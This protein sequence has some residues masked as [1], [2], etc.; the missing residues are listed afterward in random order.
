MKIQNQIICNQKFF[1][2][3][4]KAKC[5]ITHRRDEFI[6]N[7][8]G[9]VVRNEKGKLKALIYNRS[10]PVLSVF[11]NMQRKNDIFVRGGFYTHLHSEGEIRRITK[12]LNENREIGNM[13]VKALIGMGAFAFAFETE[14]GLVLKITEGKHFPYGRKPDDFDLPIIKSGKISPN[15]DLYYY[16]EEKARQDNMTD[17]EIRD[18]VG[19]IE[20]K[21]YFMR[22]YLRDFG[23]PNDPNSVIKYEQFGRA[24][25]GKIYLID[26]GCAY[27]YKNLIDDA[28]ETNFFSIILKKIKDL[29]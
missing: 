28:K 1:R 22:D 6:G 14:D 9:Q 3:N 7:Y 15:D 16:L 4:F 25:D 19:Y 23:D 17:A 13:N 8:I 29:L 27:S 10:L 24:S 12:A 2:P 21:G 26:P 18:L 20:S 11:K 5:P